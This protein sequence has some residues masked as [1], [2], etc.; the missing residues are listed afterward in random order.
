[1]N[2]GGGGAYHAAFVTHI[3]D[4]WHDNSAATTTRSYYAS[5]V[6][7]EKVLYTIIGLIRSS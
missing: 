1:M 7:W 5:D 2:V 6:T 4:A 3:S